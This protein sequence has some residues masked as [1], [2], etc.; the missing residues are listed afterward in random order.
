MTSRVVLRYWQQLTATSRLENVP[1]ARR[2]CT[3]ILNDWLERALTTDFVTN[4][5]VQ[6][7]PAAWLGNNACNSHA[8]VPCGFD[9][10]LSHIRYFRLFSWFRSRFATTM[11]AFRKS[12]RSIRRDESFRSS[13]P[14]P[15]LDSSVSTQNWDDFVQCNS[16]W[17]LDA[18]ENVLFC[19][20]D[21]TIPVVK[22]RSVR[23]GKRKGNIRLDSIW[24][25]E[26]DGMGDGWKMDTWI[27][28]TR[29]GTFDRASSLLD[30]PAVY[31]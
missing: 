3:C 19:G 2:A 6:N 1:R 23:R 4:S 15:L 30:E 17:L 31:G 29:T 10:S 18:V 7:F 20:Q 25:T 9:F 26:G 13:H 22:Q 11:N 12:S 5:S 27:N 14:M 28:S 16:N 8:L 24:M 21:V